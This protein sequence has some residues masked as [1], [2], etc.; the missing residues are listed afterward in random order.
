MKAK[1]TILFLNE[2][3]LP[4]VFTKG[5]TA[6]KELRLRASQAEI[7]AVHAVS[8]PGIQLSSQDNSITAV[9]QKI[10]VHHTI[11]W[12]YYLSSIILLLY[13][14]YYTIKYKPSTIEAESPLFSGPA[15]V[16]ISK[17]FN[18]PSVIEVRSDF[19]QLV[20]LKLKYVPISLKKK[21]ISLLQNWTI[22]HAN[23][24]ITNTRFLKAKYN[25]INSNL[26]IINPGIQYPLPKTY[27]KKYTSLF[28]FGFLGR[29]VEEKG[30]LLLIDALKILIKKDPQQSY[31]LLIAGDGP[32]KNKLIKKVA[33]NKLHQSVQFLG[34]VNPFELLQQIH[35]LVNPLTVMAPLEMAN[36]EAAFA[37]KPVICFGKD[38]IP[39]TVIHVQTGIVINPPFTSKR[40][41]DAMKKIAENPIHYRHLSTE[42]S[43]F[44][45]QNFSYSTQV[46]QMQKLYQSLGVIS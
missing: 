30:I 19:S 37:G 18:I 25:S 36:A 26:F 45:L 40:L 14:I 34:W 8:L 15:A 2:N 39:E 28:T 17:L 6:G 3:P 22:S 9:E 10:H 13:G 31:K 24:V 21:I 46:L 29:F 44:A 16:I 20:S 33:E 32:L 7:L 27:P 38:N 1:H 43:K 41:A 4:T 42:A 35:V 12:P 11:P 23:T 5:S